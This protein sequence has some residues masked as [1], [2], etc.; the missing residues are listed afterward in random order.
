MSTCQD[1]SSVYAMYISL[2]FALIMDKISHLYKEDN[3]QHYHTISFLYL[4]TT[5]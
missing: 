2:Y 5:N 3:K 1:S 4:D